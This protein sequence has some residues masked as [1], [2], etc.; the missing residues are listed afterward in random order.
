MCVLG[1]YVMSAILKFALQFG[2]SVL[3]KKSIKC[4]KDNSHRGKCDSKRPPK[5]EF[6]RFSR[7]SLVREKE[8]EVRQSLR[9][10]FETINKRKQEQLHQDENL[11]RREAE[12]KKRALEIEETSAAIISEA[13]T[14]AGNEVY[15]TIST[16]YSFHALC[17]E[18]KQPCRF[19]CSVYY[20]LI[21]Y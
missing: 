10:E 18:G 16:S 4:S 19:C 2:S 3:C 9:C 1:Q 5:V 17:S 6:W 8:K 20:I 13:D 14:R 12:V 7:K 15:H 11:T 21:T